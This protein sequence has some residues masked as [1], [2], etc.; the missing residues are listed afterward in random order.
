MTKRFNCLTKVGNVNGVPA[1]NNGFITFHTVT[2]LIKFTAFL[3]EKYPDWRYFN[4][5]DKNTKSKLGSFT[6]NRKPR[7]AYL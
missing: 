1:G 2:N 6:K 4:V 3:D 5:Y 7:A